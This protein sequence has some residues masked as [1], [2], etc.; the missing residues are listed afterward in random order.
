MTSV[1]KTLLACIWIY[2]LSML[3]LKSWMVP[4]IFSG[5]KSM[6]I[7]NR[8]QQPIESGPFWSPAVLAIFC[9]R[10][11]VSCILA[12]W[13]YANMWSW[14]VTENRGVFSHLP[15]DMVTCNAWSYFKN[16]Y[17]QPASQPS[18]MWQW[19]EGLTTEKKQLFYRFLHQQNP[20]FRRDYMGMCINTSWMRSKQCGC[21]VISRLPPAVL[22]NVYKI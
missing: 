4:Q 15:Y 12:D 13:N 18:C 22:I 19:A 20:V 10:S 1:P 3:R 16:K 5:S 14:R 17:I 11:M 2:R 6:I 9:T 21:N 7:C 8:G